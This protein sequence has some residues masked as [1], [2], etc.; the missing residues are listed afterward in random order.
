M[1]KSYVPMFLSG[2]LLMLAGCGAS[3]E[4]THTKTNAVLSGTVT[5]KGKPV[6]DAQINFENPAIGAWGTAI[7]DDGK[8]SLEIAAGEFKVS[9]LPTIDVPMDMSVN[10]DGVIPEPPKR[11]DV[12]E[13]Y[14]A[15]GTS[16]LEVTVSEGEGNTYDVTIE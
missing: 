7:G 12:P 16:G 10:S 5:S 15:G 13:K 2:C 11:E 1:V 14:R 3:T 6:K 8:Y 9:I 4:G